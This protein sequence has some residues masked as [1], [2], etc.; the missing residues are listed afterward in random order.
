ML[1]KIKD[2]LINLS[3]VRHICIFDD[4][5]RFDFS[6]DFSIYFGVDSKS[7]EWGTYGINMSTFNILKEFLETG[8]Y[9]GCSEQISI[10]DP[11]KNSP[12]PEQ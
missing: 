8:E 4:A 1:L 5:V 2:S 10:L 3:N 12:T 6:A 9:E 7:T 11:F